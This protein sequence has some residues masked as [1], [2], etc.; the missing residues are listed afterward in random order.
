M[1]DFVDRMITEY[2][3]LETK[4]TKLN[5]FIYNKK[6]LELNEENRALLNAQYNAMMAY[7]FILKR[8]IKINGGN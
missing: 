4:T 2:T 8:R 3:E 1:S 7:Q 6:Y 5:E